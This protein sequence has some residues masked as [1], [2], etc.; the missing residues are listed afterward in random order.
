[1]A[2]PLQYQ[3]GDRTEQRLIDQASA[4]VLYVGYAKSGALTNASA[5]LIKKIETINNLTTRKWADGGS[6]HDQ[7]WDNRT[8]LT[9]S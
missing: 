1:M 2:D 6:G 4:T 3:I 5:W 8:T 7:I 9:Y